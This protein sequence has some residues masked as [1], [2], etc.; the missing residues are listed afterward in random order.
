MARAII[1]NSNYGS[2]DE[3]KLAI[4]RHFRERN[5]YFQKYP[6]AAGMKIWGR[7]TSHPQFS[8]AN[9]CKDKKF[10]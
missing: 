7:E 6:K 2:A 3:A 10:R 4:D 1:H 8:E 5:E 9:N